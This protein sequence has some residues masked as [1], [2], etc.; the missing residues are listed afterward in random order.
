MNVWNCLH[1]IRTE[2]SQSPVTGALHARSIC[3]CEIETCDEG[4][5]ITPFVIMMFCCC[6]KCALAHVLPEFYHVT[7]QQLPQLQAAFENATKVLC[8]H[9][10]SFQSPGHG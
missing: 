5:E 6:K 8:Y 10:S 9:G 2:Y 1:I 4:E 7:F 3:L